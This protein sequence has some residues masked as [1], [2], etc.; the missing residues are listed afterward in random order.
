MAEVAE[1]EPRLCLLCGE[2]LPPV[3]WWERFTGTAPKTHKVNG[4]EGDLCWAKFN[5]RVGVKNPGP[6]PGT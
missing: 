3:R 6:R 4:A 1:Q 5:K 2:P